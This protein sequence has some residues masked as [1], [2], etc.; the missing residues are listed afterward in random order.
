MHTLTMV[1][2]SMLE[3]GAIIVMS[4]GSVWE[5]TCL[6]SKTTYRVRPYPWWRRLWARICFTWSDLKERW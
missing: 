3:P 2:P 4:D 5:V 6:V 1:P